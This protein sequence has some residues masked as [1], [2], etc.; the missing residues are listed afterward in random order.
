ME[1]N[2]PHPFNPFTHQRDQRHRR[3]KKQTDRTSSTEKWNRLGREDELAAGF[4]SNAR[5][6]VH[7][8]GKLEGPFIFLTADHADHADHAD[9]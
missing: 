9:A 5:F 6:L 3:L 2:G 8:F 1:H 4:M 7:A